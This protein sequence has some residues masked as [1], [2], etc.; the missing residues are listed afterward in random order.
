MKK[1]ILILILSIFGILHSQSLE[2]PLITKQDS[3]ILRLDYT[4]QYNEEHEQADWV[5]YELTRAEVLGQ[6]SRKDSFKTD[7]SVSTGSATLDDYRGSGYDRGHL[8]PAADMRM[9]SQSMSDSFYM[10]NMSPQE[11][12]FNRGIW[13]ELESYVRTWAYDNES[14]YI[15]TGPVLTKETYPTIGINQV[16]VPEYYYKV[17]LDYTEP[18]IKA[19]G[20]ILPN[21]KGTKTVQ[22]YAVSVDDVEAFTGIDFYPTLIDSQEE[23]LESR[24]DIHQ[25]A[26]EKFSVSDHLQAPAQNTI[27]S[28]AQESPMKYWINSS[29]N[30]RHNSSCR[31]YGNT[32]NGYYTN[33]LIGE[34]CSICG[35]Y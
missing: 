12:S 1:I 4:L 19:I 14:V 24:Y 7:S 6:T 18:E 30:T 26:F 31:Y 2:I 22:D 13:S 9:N 23:L 17:V 32:A 11:P 8:A 35:G 15:V 33:E 28:Q 25:W 5:A 29:S 34:P 20:F 16:A 21:A 10:S 27:Q 3:I